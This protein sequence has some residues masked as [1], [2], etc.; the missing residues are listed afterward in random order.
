MS[1]THVHTPCL[2]SIIRHKEAARAAETA[3][4]EV[5]RLN[6]ENQ[7]VVASMR[8]MEANLK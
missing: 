6:D 3:V 1:T 4:L 7:C 5:Q 8:K 2:V